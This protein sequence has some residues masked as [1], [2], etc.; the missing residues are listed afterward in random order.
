M[1][2]GVTRRRGGVVP[3]GWGGV[4]GRVCA[5]VRAFV[6]VRVRARARA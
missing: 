5:R 2:G 6:C 1:W 4:E 3:W